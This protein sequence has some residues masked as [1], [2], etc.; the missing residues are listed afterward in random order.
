MDLRR[1]VTRQRQIMERYSTIIVMI[2]A[3]PAPSSKL[4]VDGLFV[5]T[6]K[7]LTSRVVAT[8][9]NFEVVYS[10]AISNTNTSHVSRFLIVIFYQTHTDPRANAAITASF[11]DCDM[12]N[13]LIGK[14]GMKNMIIS[15]ETWNTA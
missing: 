5:C 8:S 6:A 9:R 12:F 14:I 7:R 4:L 13:L 10:N 2:T 3:M 15:V 11:R 1:P